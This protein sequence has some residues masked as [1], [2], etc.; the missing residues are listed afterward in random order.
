MGFNARVV[1]RSP[2]AA[3]KG[4]HDHRQ[5]HSYGVCGAKPMFVICRGCSGHK[6]SP[7]IVAGSLAKPAACC[8]NARGKRCPKLITTVI[9]RSP[10]PVGA[11]PQV[12][13][14]CS[15][16]ICYNST[17]MERVHNRI[18]Q[19]V[20]GWIPLFV[21]PATAVAFGR[22]LPPWAFMWVLSF[23]IFFSLKWLTWWQAR[24]HTAHRAWRSLAYLL[25]WPG[26]DAE[27]FLDPAQRGSS[28]AASRWV[29]PAFKAGLGILLLWVMARAI[30]EREALLRGWTG[31]AGIILILHFGSFDMIA[32]LWQ[33]L[34]INAEPIMRAPLGSTSLAEFWGKRWNL[35]FR[36]LA[37]ELIF[38]PAYRRV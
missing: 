20:C 32:L 29:A 31:L 25:A 2:K 34:G 27:A 21:L 12:P 6:S 36:Q 11:S 8:G 33:H 22:L 28:A 24:A 18:V 30:P 26:M 35:G 9:P 19:Q 16:P 15:W 3:N 23:A 1:L 4:E 7:E 38:R 37:H 14:F 5:D 10:E 17:W 13:L